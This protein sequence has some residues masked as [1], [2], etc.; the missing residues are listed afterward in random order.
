VLLH[1]DPPPLSASAR[2]PCR[3]ATASPDH[4]SFPYPWACPDGE[5]DDLADLVGGSFGLAKKRLLRATPTSPLFLLA[6]F[7]V[8]ALCKN[9]KL[10]NCMMQSNRLAK[11][12]WIVIP[13]RPM[14]RTRGSRC[15][16]PATRRQEACHRRATHSASPSTPT[17]GSPTPPHM[18]L[19]TSYWTTPEPDP[20][21]MAVASAW[22]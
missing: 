17:G 12:N 1:N 18:S 7:I 20:S 22:S 21:P 6:K 3:H 19:S 11:S 14:C 9:R 2:P 15:S 8:S 13:A 4:N 10:N 16:L 5:L